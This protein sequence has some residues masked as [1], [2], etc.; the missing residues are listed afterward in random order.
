MTPAS[1]AGSASMGMPGEREQDGEADEGEG[2]EKDSAK[3]LC[4][5]K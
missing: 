4:V 1:A 5:E 3:V 2:D